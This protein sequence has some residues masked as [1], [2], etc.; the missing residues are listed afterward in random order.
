MPERPEQ[1]PQ[2]PLNSDGAQPPWPPWPQPAVPPLN[3][4]VPIP[5]KYLSNF[6]YHWKTVK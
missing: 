5:L 1:Q 4:E 2:P 6:W 3:A